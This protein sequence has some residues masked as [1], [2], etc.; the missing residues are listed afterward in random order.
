MVYT[1]SKRFQKFELILF[2]ENY[3]EDACYTLMFFQPLYNGEQLY[4]FKPISKGVYYKINIFGLL[5]YFI[6]LFIYLFFV[7]FAHLRTSC[8]NMECENSEAS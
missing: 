5:I 6:Y 2:K 4:K 1:A 8:W 3:S 7:S